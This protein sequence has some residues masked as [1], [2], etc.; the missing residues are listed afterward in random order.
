MYNIVILNYTPLETVIIDSLNIKH[1]A[2]TGRF[3]GV[4]NYV[5]K[6]V[7]MRALFTLFISFQDLTT[8]IG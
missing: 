7:L 6:E 3:W 5:G 8:K 2:L 4:G 1:S